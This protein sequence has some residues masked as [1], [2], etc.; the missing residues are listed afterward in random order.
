MFGLL[1]T[2]V[3]TLYILIAA[4]LQGKVIDALGKREMKTL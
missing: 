3:M 2:I 4:V 1:F